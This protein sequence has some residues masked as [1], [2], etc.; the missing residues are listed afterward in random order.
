[1]RFLY[2]NLVRPALF[3]VDAETAHNLSLAALKTGA[4]LV[5]ACPKHEGLAT[6]V[7]G[8]RFPNPIGLAAGYDKNCEVPD[9]LLSMGFGF[10]ETGTVTPKAQPGNP[11]PRLFRLEEDAGIINRFGFNNVGHAVFLERLRRHEASEGVIGVNIGANKDSAD[12]IADYEAGVRTFAPHAS[13]LAVNISSPNTPG[14][15]A[16]QSR[17]ALAEL[18]GRVIAARPKGKGAKTPIFLKIAPDMPDDELSDVATEVLGHRLD[19]IIVSNTTLSRTGLR[20]PRASETGGLSGAPL[21]HRSTVVLARLRLLVGPKLPLIGVGG[22]DSAATAVEKIR[23][24]A[25]LVQVYT[26]L[27]YRGPGLPCDIVAGLAREMRQRG[28][29]RLGDMRD[30]TVREW[31]ARTIN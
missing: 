8:I 22:V 12:R 5:F 29:K 23:A 26:G 30:E 19:G 16:L 13:Y 21:F 2:E 10:V 6:R 11:K 3:R 25:D 17:A 28:L 1:L 15:R 18:L 4:G 9:A 7:A 24:G 20:S 27:V 31:A 14:L